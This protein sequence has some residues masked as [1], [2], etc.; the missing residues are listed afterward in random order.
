VDNEKV[1]VFNLTNLFMKNEEV[2]G[3]DLKEA[4]KEAMRGELEGRELYSLTAEKVTDE[5]AKQIF[6]HLAQEEYSHYKTL[7][8]IAKNYFEGKPV[9]VPKL[10]KLVSFEDAKSPIF[11]EDF[12]NFLKDKHFE[13]SALSI[14]MKLE[15]ESSK[16]YKEMADAIDD[17]TIKGLFS[18]LSEWEKGHYD[19]LKN[20]VAYLKEHYE[21]QN[22]LFRF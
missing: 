2:K 15:L 7:E 18:E 17:E 6:E 16:I 20:Q 3:M 4:F 22:S 8:E 11:T 12:K 9:K 14:G 13:M 19:A 5:K 10:S 1:A 21:A